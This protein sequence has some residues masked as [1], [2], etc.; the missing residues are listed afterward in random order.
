MKG[1]SGGHGQKLKADTCGRL[2]LL[3]TEQLIGNAP[4]F[5]EYWAR[6]GLLSR[7]DRSVLKV[8]QALSN[9]ENYLAGQRAG[10]Q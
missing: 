3:Q 4:A 6:E 9:E 5:L 8:G 2:L 10:F 1:A 7:P